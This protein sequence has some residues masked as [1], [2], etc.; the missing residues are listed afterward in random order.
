MVEILDV[1]P[2]FFVTYVLSCGGWSRN[3]MSPNRIFRDE[4]L[5][6]MEIFSQIPLMA[7]RADAIYGC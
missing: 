4:M 5:V 1:N 3:A 7:V 6:K 2:K